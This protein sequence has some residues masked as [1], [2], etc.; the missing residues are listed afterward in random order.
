M[1]V[2]AIE[3]NSSSRRAQIGVCA[4]IAVLIWIV[5]GQTLSHDFINYDDRTYVYGNALV[6]GG[7]T[8]HGLAHAF[9]DVRTD[10]WHPLTLISHMIDCQIFALKPGGHHFTNVLLQSVAAVLLLV[11]LNGLTG[12]LWR[13]AFV[14]ALFAIHPLRVESVAWIAE[15]KDVLSAVFFFLTLLAYTRYVRARSFGHYFTMSILFACALMSKPMVV[16]TP[17]VLLLLDYWPFQRITDSRSLRRMILEK[18]PLLGLSI[19][20]SIVA[21]ALQVH[22]PGMSA[23]PLPVLWRVENAVVSYFIY[24][25]QLF[26]PT[27]LA[28]FYPHPDDRLAWWQVTLASVF[29]IGISVIVFKLRQTRPY[30]LF[31]WLWYL[32]MLLPVI[33]IIEVG[34]QGHADRYTYLPQIGLLIMIAWGA[35]D[36]LKTSNIERRTLNTEQG[37]RHSAFDVRRSVFGVFCVA[38]IIILAITARAH[39]FYWRNSETLW[40]HALAVTD[41]N[42]VANTNLGMRLADLGKF[43]DA[44]SHLA[45]ALD[46]RSKNSHP[47]YDLSF[48]IILGDV[49]EVLFR[50]NRLDEAVSYFRRSLQFRP[51]YPYAR[52]NLGMTLFRKGDT[53]EAIAEWQRVLSVQKEDPGTLTDIGNALVQKGSIREAIN[54]Y[55]RALR[56]DPQSERAL[57][58]LAWILAVAPNQSLRNGARAIELAQKANRVTN[59]SDPICIRTE[60]AAYAEAGQFQEAIAV[61]QR[62]SE[63][64][65][66]LG[67]HD[68]ALQIQ[69]EIDL[70]R[71]HAPL[72]DQTL[73]DAP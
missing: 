63:K 29:L 39:V 66:A 20:A 61:A 12:H 36:L 2:R 57:N 48:A 24:I 72:R 44:L 5:F 13:S 58:N 62:A 17:V 18:L 46:V 35:A 40:T 71:R 69:D 23:G 8:F 4:I 1:K 64:A 60:A 53:D 45:T 34:L 73:S 65:D 19:G 26:W 6:S 14:T 52:Y 42:A 3:K 54:Y 32:I 27:G 47:Y 7:L 33:G 55:E 11:W 51:D 10:N 9:V 37:T 31:G 43:D 56:S 41:D 38:I 22:S 50:Q 28:V 49:G 59:Q 70:F 30:L 21:L 67:Q 15:R 25:R 68:L 16:T